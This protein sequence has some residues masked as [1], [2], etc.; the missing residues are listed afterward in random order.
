MRLLTAIILSALAGGLAYGVTV[1]L[2]S[3]SGSALWVA[4]MVGLV[5]ALAILVP[6]DLIEAFGPS[7]KSNW[8]ESDNAYHSLE[9]RLT[10]HTG[11]EASEYSPEE[12]DIDRS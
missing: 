7:K 6:H 9:F 4:S 3:D 11:I 5:T 12:D 10:N 2:A 8:S 1:W